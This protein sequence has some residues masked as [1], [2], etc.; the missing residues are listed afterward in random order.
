MPAAAL[1][2]RWKRWCEESEGEGLQ[3]IGGDRGDR[4]LVGLL[5]YVYQPL[6]DKD[7]RQLS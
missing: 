1:A 2:F 5:C 3:S 7:K 4:P 6:C